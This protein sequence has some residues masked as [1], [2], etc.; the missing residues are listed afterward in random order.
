MTEDEFDALPRVEKDILLWRLIREDKRAVGRI[1]AELKA[2]PERSEELYPM[3]DTTEERLIRRRH[4][5]DKV[6]ARA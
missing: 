4:E 1:R 6:R 5:R 2:K 3:L